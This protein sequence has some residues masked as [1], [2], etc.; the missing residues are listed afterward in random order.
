M[1][2]IRPIEPSEW[3]L[4]RDIRLQ[5]L[6]DAPD[7]FGSTWEAEVTRTDENWSARI[8]AAAISGK[9]RALLAW[10]GDKAC[11]LVWCKLSATDPGVADLFQMWVAPAVRGRG[12]GHALLAEAIVWARRM[13]MRRV[14]LGVTDD[15]SPAMRLY[16][17]HGFHAVGA[18]EPLR[19]GADLMA[20][21][22][23]LELG[24]PESVANA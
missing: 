3:S 18:P 15:D 2:T 7:A 11:G 23:V 13:G 8:A 17:A 1:I 4:Y 6:Q 12:A 20:R 21:T 24:R 14:C 22:M 19:E 16:R 5:A 10:D 9:D